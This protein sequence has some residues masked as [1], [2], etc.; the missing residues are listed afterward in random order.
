M[1]A[2]SPLVAFLVSSLAVVT[3]LGHHAV[4]HILLSIGHC[5]LHQLSL[6]QIFVV[7]LA[8][9]S[10]LQVHALPT[11]LLAL[12]QVCADVAHVF[13]AISYLRQIGTVW[14]FI[15]I[16]GRFVVSASTSEFGVDAGLL[17]SCMVANTANFRVKAVCLFVSV[18]SA[19]HF[20][21]LR[22]DAVAEVFFG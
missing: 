21:E 6:I 18:F 12:L 5:Y 14:N 10:K 1:N 9:S 13:R 15:G 16:F 4:P 3:T 20:T 7:M 2:V 8:D 17:V 11:L 22:G 19:A